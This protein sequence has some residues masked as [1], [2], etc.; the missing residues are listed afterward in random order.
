MRSD[1]RLVLMP[2]LARGNHAHPRLGGCFAE[3]AATLTTHRW[4]DHPACLPP[5]LG[6]IARGVND[7]TSPGARTALAPLI[8]WA[9]CT[10]CPS[11]DLASDTATTAALISL[12]RVQHPDDPGLAP[13]AQR[14]ERPPRPGHLLDRIGWRRAARHLVHSYLRFITSSAAHEPVRDL[15]LR[16]LLVTA[17]NTNRAVDGLP[18]LPVAPEA[19]GTSTCLLPVTVHYA[20]AHDAFELRV[21]PLLDCWPDW[22]RHPWNQRTAEL[23]APAVTVDRSRP[24]PSRRDRETVPV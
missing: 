15:R 22:I 24:E 11:K 12:I 1:E 23:S 4:T 3:V 10:P 2:I 18:P 14:L 5:V 19:T 21:E 9:I 6:Q 13:L 8:P 16:E 17:I 20:A 7:R